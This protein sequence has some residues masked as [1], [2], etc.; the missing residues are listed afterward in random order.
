MY[1]LLSE[2]CNYSKPKYIVTNAHMFLWSSFFLG[3]VHFHN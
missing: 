3:G 2:I 1:A